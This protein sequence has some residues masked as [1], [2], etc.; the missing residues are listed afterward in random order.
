VQKQSI[1]ACF[2]VMVLH[3]NRIWLTL[4]Q[5]LNSVTLPTQ[6]DGL[7]DAEKATENKLKKA[8]E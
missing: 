8:V 3:F 6:S 5:F 7:G 1:E 4:S 2:P